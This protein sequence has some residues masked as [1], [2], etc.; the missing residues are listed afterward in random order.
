MIP[1]LRD[2]RSLLALLL[3]GCLS[4]C[5]GE[6]ANPERFLDGGA[7][8][9]SPGVD[10]VADILGSATCAGPGCHAADIPNVAPDLASPGVAERLID[11]PTTACPDRVLIDSVNPAQSYL[12]ESLKPS[13]TCG[14]QMPVGGALSEADIACVEEWIGSL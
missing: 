5:A 2:H 10:V 14:G 3:L 12:L 13:P 8:A 9:C 11:V 6:L 1:L 7:A 4:G